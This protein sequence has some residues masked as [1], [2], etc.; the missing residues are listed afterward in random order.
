VDQIE[1]ANSGHPGIALGAAPILF[2]L[3]NSVMNYNANNPNFFNRDRFVLSAGHG[4]SLLYSTLHMFG[5]DINT[6]DLKNFRRINSITPGH[7]EVFITPGVETSTGPLGQGVSN[8]VGMAMASKHLASIYNTKKHQ[9]I[10]NNIYC[11]AGDGCFMEGITTEALSLAGNLA[12]DNFVLIYDYNKITIEGSTELALNEDVEKKFK[13]LNFE[14]FIVEDG[15]NLSVLE[16]QLLKAKKQEKK[17]SVVIVKTKIGYG[18]DLEGSEKAHGKPLNKKQIKLLKQNLN[19]ENEPFEVNKQV[20]EYVLLK[21]KQNEKYEN[22]WNALLKEYENENIGLFEQF[23]NSLNNEYKQIAIKKLE[24]LQLDNDLPLREMGHN[25][26]Q[27]LKLIMP[28]LIGGTADVAPSTKAY[29]KDLGSFL[30]NNYNGKNI[31]YGIREHAMAGIANGITLFGGVNT[32]VSTYVAF[33]D[34]M[35]ASMRLSAL[36]KLPVLYYLTHDSVLIGQDGATHQPVEQLLSLRATPNLK[37]FR[38][39]NNAEVIASF[40]NHM[41]ESLP[42]A[43]VFSKQKID[44]DSSSIK[45]ALKGAYIFKTEKSKAKLVIIA[46]GSEVEIAVKAAN[47]LEQNGISTRVVSM[48]CMKNFDKQDEKY[49][50]KILPKKGV[51]TIAVEAGSSYSFYKYVN[52]SDVVLGVDN[53]GSSGTSEELRQAFKLTPEHIIDTAENMF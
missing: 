39:C 9:L 10:N 6:K 45:D 44:V 27:E 34:Y 13:S 3:Y 37:V 23:K 36:M 43:I 38:P 4:S 52:S 41:E 31:H 48:L 19:F 30:K 25:V 24:K 22:N 35:K 8:A 49:K 1:K 26:L 40:I 20:K 18:S 51:K 47:K 17:P 28:N 12:L 15:N 46:T 7:P 42:S 14:V 53:F 33:I 16:E 29:L 5:Y 11:L 2:T 50:N 21:Q 32:F